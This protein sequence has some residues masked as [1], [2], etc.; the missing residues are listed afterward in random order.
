MAL[1]GHNGAGK[2]SFL[3]L[4]SGIYQ[5]TSGYFKAHTRCSDDSRGF[6]TSPELSGL[7]AIKARYLLAHGHLGGF[8]EF[9]EDVIDFLV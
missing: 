5:H 7:Q 9:C 4:V 3:R 6:V 8:E 2:S 1:I